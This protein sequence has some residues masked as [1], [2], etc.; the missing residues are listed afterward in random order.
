LRW[1]LAP[2]HVPRQ[3]TA[4]YTPPKHATIGLARTIAPDGCQ[5]DIACGQ[6]DVGNAGTPL[7]AR[8]ARSAPKADGM[9]NPVATMDLENV[10]R[11]I[12]HLAGL[13]QDANVLL[14]TAM[15]TEMP[16]VGRG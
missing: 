5:H 6:I 12:V 8:M 10:R 7:V 11:N 3:G 14:T 4:P 16:F 15:E 1:S 2:T 9:H 13:R